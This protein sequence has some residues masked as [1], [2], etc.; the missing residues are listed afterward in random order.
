MTHCRFCSEVL[1]IPFIDLGMSPLANSFIEP[2]NIDK[3]ETLFPLKVMVCRNCFLVQLEE[4][5]KPE[6]IFT[7]YIYFSSYSQSWLQHSMQYVNRVIERFK[8]NSRSKIIEIASNDGYLLQYFVSKGFDV[9]G[10]EPAKNIAKTAISIGV[11]TLQEF[12]NTETAGELVYKGIKAD[13]LIANN[14]L[15]HVPNLNDF[16][17]AVK[18]V[19]KDKAIFTAEF[20]HLMEL[21]KKNQFDTIYHEHYSYFSFLTINKIFKHHGLKIFDVEKLPTHGGSLRI[22]ATQADNETFPENKSIS[23]LLELEFKHSLNNINAYQG[24]AKK[25]L[26]IREDM[27]KLLIKLKNEGNKI[28]AYSAPAKGNT[29]LNYCAIGNDIIDFTVDL[30][31][32]K[33]GKYLPGT[34]IPVYN[35][36]IIK[37]TKPDYLLI[38]SWNIK[39]EI[40]KQMNYVRNWGGKFIIPIPEVTIIN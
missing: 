21:I 34:K 40:V 37:E 28:S 27:R 17:K 16:I 23:L 18:L 8:L 9:L 36:R 29:L 20:P 14:V 22:Y 4:F 2:E 7:D 31:P 3:P 5:E 12:F 26:I 32:L 15:A 25:V 33:Q 11:P 10:I 30:N 13:L 38:L 1:N 6:D 39:D 19:L 35:P 24:F